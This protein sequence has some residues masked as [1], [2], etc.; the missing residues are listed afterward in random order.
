MPKR[1]M[2]ISL[3]TPRP[4]TA[5]TGRTNATRPSA[6]FFQK[7]RKR[8]DRIALEAASLPPTAFPPQGCRNW[9]TSR[10]HDCLHSIPCAGR[11]GRLDSKLN[12][13]RAW[14]SRCRLSSAFTAVE[15][16]ACHQPGFGAVAASII[17]FSDFACRQ[18]TPDLGNSTAN[19]VASASKMI[20]SIEQEQLRKSG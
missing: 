13:Q 16:R 17:W 2:G 20:I 4:S 9:V 10:T 11:C 3:R 18:G 7:N 14:S 5:G 19:G 6:I 12:D 8:C 1:C 15:N